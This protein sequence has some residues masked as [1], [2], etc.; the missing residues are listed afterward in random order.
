MLGTSPRATTRHSRTDAGRKCHSQHQHFSQTNAEATLTNTKRVPAALAWH[1]AH[2]RG[3]ATQRCA[4]AACDRR[5]GRASSPSRPCCRTGLL[6]HTRDS[7]QVSHARM[8]TVRQTDQRSTELIQISDEWLTCVRAVQV[9]VCCGCVGSGCRTNSPVL[10][11]TAPCL[12]WARCDCLVCSKSICTCSAQAQTA[13]HNSARAHTHIH[14]A[15]A[16]ARTQAG[17]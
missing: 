14:A 15:H 9:C 3:G 7:K 12:W 8:S 17:G 4:S 1:D 11:K 16:Q 10:A 2:A 13:R 5:R 6:V